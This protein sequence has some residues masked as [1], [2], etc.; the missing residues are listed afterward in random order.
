MPKKKEHYVSSWRYVLLICF[1]GL[2]FSIIAAQLVFLQIVKGNYFRNK[3]SNQSVRKLWAPALRGAIFDKNGVLLA[4]NRPSFDID[5]NVDNLTKKQTTNLVKQLSVL[6]RTEKNILWRRLDPKKRLPYTAARIAQDVSFSNI[7]RVA[8]ILNEIPEIDIRVRPMRY[9]PEAELA[10]HILGY[11]GKIPPNHPKLLSR[12]YSLHDKVGVS[13]IELICENLLHGKN[14]KKIVQVDRSSKFVETLDYVPPVQGQDII[15]TIDA[16]LQKTIESAFSNKLGAAVAINPNNGEILAL[17]SSPGFNPEIFAGI[18]SPSAYNDLMTDKKKPLFNRAISSAYTLG[19]VFKIITAIAGLESGVINSNTVFHDSGVYRLGKMKVRNFHNHN[20]GTMKLPYA[21]RVSCNTFFCNYSTQIGIKNLANYASLFGFGKKTGIEL[22][23][24]TAG[25]LGSRSW[26]RKYKHLPWFPGDT[27]NLSIGHGFLIVTPIQVANMIAAVANGGILH[28]PHLIAG[29]SFGG[30]FSPAKNISP[31][32]PLPINKENLDIVRKGLWEVVNT[33]N[34]TG[35][36]CKIPGITIAG[37]TG[38]ALLENETLAWFAA[39]APFDK[40]EIAI[41]VIVEKG[42]TGG[43]D[44]APIAKAA[45]AE[46][47]GIDLNQETNIINNTKI[48][49]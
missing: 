15:L 40:P 21:L 48:S 23:A 35:K 39:Y 13:G 36:R 18:V 32:V 1:V 29:Y 7:V 2:V 4:G 38:S 5:V 26:K 45:F 42:T 30:I 44:A 41:A 25:L 8:E 27:V 49:Y 20:Y 17:V 14:G 46:Y 24:E 28:Q 10:S 31:G 37:K 43:R 6:L 33:E 34:G 16:E 3:A 9:Y 12:Q 19:S 11:V 47:F 22:P